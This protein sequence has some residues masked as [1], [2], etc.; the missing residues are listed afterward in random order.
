M[1]RLA[2]FAVF[3]ALVSWWLHRRLVRATGLGRPWSVV[4]DVTLV[5][6]W[7]LAVIGV[8]SG[9]AFDPG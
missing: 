9:E 6:L 3:L 5:V 1:T 7:V 4:V 8:G 2:V